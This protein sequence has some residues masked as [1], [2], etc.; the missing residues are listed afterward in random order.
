MHSLVLN[1]IQA[2]PV[3]LGMYLLAHL[4]KNASL[5]AAAFWM[6]VSPQTYMLTFGR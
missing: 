5:G 1:C 2:C 3:G 6:S 4:F